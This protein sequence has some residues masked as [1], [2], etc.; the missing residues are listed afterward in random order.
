[1]HYTYIIYS[2]STDRFYIGSTSDEISQ[3]IRRHNAPHRGFTSM[4]NDWRLVYLEQFDSI[5]QARKR[6]RQI[7]AWKSRKRMNLLIRIFAFLKIKEPQPLF[8]VLHHGSP[9]PTP[10]SP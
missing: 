4:A 1:M 6:E 3:R 8:Q 7:K 10:W 2:S 9:L 5:Q